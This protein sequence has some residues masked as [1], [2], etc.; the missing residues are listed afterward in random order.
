MTLEPQEV[1]IGTTRKMGEKLKS[2]KEVSAEIDEKEKERCSTGN[3]LFGHHGDVEVAASRPTPRLPYK[4]FDGTRD[5]MA[6]YDTWGKSKF[7]EI[8][9][10][11]PEF[12]PTFSKVRIYGNNL[13][14]P[15]IKIRKRGKWVT[16]EPTNVVKDK[17]M[18]GFD[19]PESYKTVKFHIDFPLNKLELYE[20]EML[21]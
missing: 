15:T 17:Y 16:L 21:E 20:I 4:M 7:Y 11:K 19:F 9:F 12:I 8:S 5:V 14:T 18:I 10:P 1:I 6:F 13:G 3:L 2:Y